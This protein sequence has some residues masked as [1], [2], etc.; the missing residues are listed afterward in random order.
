MKENEDKVEI[1]GF[2]EGLANIKN[3]FWGWF[4]ANWRWVFGI[5][6]VGTG[7]AIYMLRRKHDKSSKRR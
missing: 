4:K 7:I 1:A 2:Q 6:V 5:G 3:D